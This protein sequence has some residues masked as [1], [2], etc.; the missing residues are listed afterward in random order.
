MKFGRLAAT[1]LMAVAAVGI[2]AGTVNATPTAT[3]APSTS[4]SSAP[5]RELTSS[6]VD[7]GVAY[8]A[9]LSDDERV[10][11]T[12]VENGRFEA[13]DDGKRV[14]LRSDSGAVVAE[15]PLSFRVR[16]RLLP[17]AQHISPDGRTL[18]LTPDSAAAQIGELQ[19]VDP[20]SRLITE[21]NNNVVGMVIGGVLGGLIGA[22][23]GFFFLS[24]LTGPIGLLVGALAGGAIMGGQPFVD[25]LMGVVR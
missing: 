16:D 18:S 10:L 6:G 13:V 8:R 14:T 5:A 2:A 12:T 23:L 21:L 17:V 25:A 15:V 20:M 4:A 7:Q 1:T 19:P 11:T 3:P 22:V 24:W 9:A